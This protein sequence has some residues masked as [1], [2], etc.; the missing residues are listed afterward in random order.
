MA[1]NVFQQVFNDFAGI[2]CIP[3]YVNLSRRL[4]AGAIGKV[5]KIL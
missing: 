3:F 5:V 2:L 4:R 1:A